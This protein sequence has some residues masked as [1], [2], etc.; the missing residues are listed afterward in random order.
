M[1][2]SLELDT[3]QFGLDHFLS[4]VAR[5]GFEDRIQQ[6]VLFFEKVS[7]TTG[8][9]L[10]RFIFG[11]LNEKRWDFSK[12]VSITTDG[13]KNMVSPQRGM[14]NEIVKMAMMHST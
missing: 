13:A 14:A 2:F 12:L 11:R 6:E 1:F 5:F 3:A 7:E 4:C 8:H 10:A 9:G